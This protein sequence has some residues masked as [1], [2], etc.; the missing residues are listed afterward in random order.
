[1]EGFKDHR[2][3]T[4]VFTEKHLQEFY[5]KGEQ[6]LEIAG[7]VSEGKIKVK[8]KDQRFE[9]NI[10]KKGKSFQGQEKHS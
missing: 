4:N 2:R 3:G 8:I 10:L 6:G 5:R 7:K 1:M 9:E